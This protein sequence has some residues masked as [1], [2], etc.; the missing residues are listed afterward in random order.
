MCVLTLWS[1]TSSLY[2][3]R[4]HVSTRTS[5]VLTWAFLT[6]NHKKSNRY[7]LRAQVS[8]ADNGAPRPLKSY[9]QLRSTVRNLQHSCP[10][11]ILFLFSRSRVMTLTRLLSCL[12][13][14]GA[15]ISIWNSCW[16]EHAAG[17]HHLRGGHL[18]SKRQ[19]HEASQK[20]RKETQIG[21]C[22]EII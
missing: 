5:L 20:E 19:R 6:S 10:M 18:K 4:G 1:L 8:S 3:L 15:P 12:L 2:S 17:H 14:T 13:H 21:K 16:E 9:I 7:P 11:N 22:V